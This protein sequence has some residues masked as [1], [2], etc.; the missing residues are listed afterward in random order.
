MIGA[1]TRDK[2]DM[3]AIMVITSEVVSLVLTLTKTDPEGGLGVV[4]TLMATNLVMFEN[5]R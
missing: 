1:L 3:V 2:R 5:R 4:Q